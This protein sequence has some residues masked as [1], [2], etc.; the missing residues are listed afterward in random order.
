MTDRPILFSAPMV[1][2]LLAGRKTQTRRLLRQPMPEPPAM[3]AIY[4]GNEAKHPAPYFDAYCGAMKTPGNPRGMTDRWCWWTRDDRQSLPAVKVGYVPGD[5]LWVREGWA[6]VAA[7]PDASKPRRAWYRC[8]H[9]EERGYGPRTDVRWRVSIHMPRWASRLTLTV[10]DVRVQK[11]QDITEA[12]AKAEGVSLY[13]AEMAA[14]YRVAFQDVW[15]RLHGRGAWDANPE[16]IA[17]SFAV[18]R[19]NV[20][21]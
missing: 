10:T 4:P 19:K 21:A 1:L 2:A 13:P 6:P 12:D 7:S 5:R 17:I 16:V 11:L 3:D 15:N 14:Y 8:G 20:D 18:E 9:E